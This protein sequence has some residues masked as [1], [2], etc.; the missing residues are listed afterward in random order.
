MLLAVQLVGS[1]LLTVIWYVTQ[2][3]SL[4]TVGC[5]VLDISLFWSMLIQLHAVYVVSIAE[6]LVSQRC[7][8]WL[9]HHRRFPL[10]ELSQ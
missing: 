7:I 8:H 4:T 9:I 10:L 1:E 2:L 5:A 3:S 6:I